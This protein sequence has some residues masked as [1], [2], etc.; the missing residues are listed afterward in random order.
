MSILAECPSCRK[1]QAVKNRLCSCGEDLVK[2]K[3]SERV[4]Y[5][6]DFYVPGGKHRREAAGYS[7]EKARDAMGKRRGQ[8][9]EGRIFDMLPESKTTYRELTTWYLKLTSR[10]GLA[11][12]ERMVGC[13]DNFNAVF[14]NRVVNDT[15][16]ADLEDYQ[17]KRKADGRADAT[18]DMEIRIVKTMV[19]K[20]FNNDLVGGRTIPGVQHG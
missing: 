5:W 17:A 1:K 13:L 20:A 14:G 11:S 2:A 4:R 16:P 3:K 15:K 18:V 6:I 19:K 7:I 10:K 9:R 12:Y 8:K